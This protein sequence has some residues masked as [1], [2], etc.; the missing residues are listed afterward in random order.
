MRS[1]RVALLGALAA[2]STPAGLSD[3]GRRDIDRPYTL[4]ADV[5]TWITYAPIRYIG[6]D[7]DAD[8]GDEAADSKIVTSVPMPVGYEISLGSRVTLEAAVIPLGVRVQLARSDRHL[9]GVRAGSSLLGFTR[10]DGGIVGGGVWGF[11][12]ALLG[13]SWALETTAGE[14]YV[15][16]EETPNYVDVGLTTGPRGQLTDTLSVRPRISVTARREDGDFSTV[17]PFGADLNW[18]LH[19]RWSVNL[20]YAGNLEQLGYSRTGHLGRLKVILY[21]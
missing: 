20:D 11:H 17:V 1:C 18:N 5:N 16:R 14:S 19:R 3:Y 8:P 6:P 12:R 13:R 10:A 9:F 2:C 7:K 4:P 15:Y 21:W